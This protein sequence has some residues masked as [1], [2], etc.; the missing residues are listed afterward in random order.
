[1]YPSE[2]I[3]YLILFSLASYASFTDWKYRLIYD[4]VILVGLLAAIVCRFFYRSASWWD[5]IGTGLITLIVL[6]TIAVITEGKAIGGGDIKLLSMLGF[7][8][9][10]LPFLVLFFIAHITASFFLLIWKVFQDQTLNKDTTLP[11]APFILLGLIVTKT[12]ML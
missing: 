4:R 1:M 9:G 8:L 5:Y 11:F 10:F 12:V 6:S 3:L 7:A 2:E